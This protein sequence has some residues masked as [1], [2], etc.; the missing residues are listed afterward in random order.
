VSFVRCGG[1]YRTLYDERKAHLAA[2]HPEWPAKRVHLAAVR[3]RVKRFLA[4]LWVAGREGE[5]G[6]GGNTTAEAR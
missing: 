6:A 5:G 2:H 3:G 1:P 4:V